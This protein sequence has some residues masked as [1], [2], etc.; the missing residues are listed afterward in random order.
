MLL[1]VLLVSLGSVNVCAGDDDDANEISDC[2]GLE[3]IDNDL[4][5]DYILVN[6]IDCSDHGNFDRIGNFSGTF[7]GDDYVI[8][9]ITIVNDG[10]DAYVGFFSQ[11]TAGATVQNVTFKDFTITN[12]GDSAYVG[13]L[14]GI[15]SDATVHHVRFI[16]LTLNLTD[17]AAEASYVGGAIGI[18][19]NM[20]ISEVAIMGDSVV[21]AD[22][23][24]GGLIGILDNDGGDGTDQLVDSFSTADVNA[25]DYVGG[26]VGNTSLVLDGDG[27]EISR[28]YVTG[29]VVG[30]GGNFVGA[31]VGTNVDFD[32]S[33]T[34]FRYNFATGTALD[35][36]YGSGADSTY[37]SDNYYTGSLCSA[38][39]TAGCI[40]D[41]DETTW[42]N[43]EST[44]PLNQWDFDDVWV[45]QANALPI[46]RFDPVIEED[47]AVDSLTNDSTPSYV[48][49]STGAGDITYGGDCSS[50]TDTAVAGENTIVFEELDDGTYDDCTITV[51]DS[52][53]IDSNVLAITAFS[54]DS[55]NPTMTLA[56]STV[57]ENDY[58]NSE[59][60][61]FTATFSEDV[62][63]FTSGDVTISN[64]TLSGFTT[65]TAN[66][67]YSFNVIPRTSGEVTVSIADGAAEDSAE[68]DTE[69]DFFSFGFSDPGGG[70]VAQLLKLRNSKQNGVEGGSA[71]AD[72][73]ASFKDIDGHF[74]EESVEKLYELGIVEGRG[75]GNFEPN[76]F[77]TRAEMVKMALLAFD[78]EIDAD[79]GVLE[80]F[81]DLLEG[82]WYMKYLS[83]AVKSEILKGYDGNILRPDGFVTRAEALKVLL[84]CAE[85]S[86][87]NPKSSSFTDVGEQ[88]WFKE[89]VD[90]AYL[91]GVIKGR[92]A[93]I[94]APNEFATRGE[95]A[96]MITRLFEWMEL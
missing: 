17:G 79:I 23:Y 42:Y 92:T 74:A 38:G 26:F 27:G 88:D 47:T 10:D 32:E 55:E 66:R 7:D 5:A 77:L 15:A 18:A 78:Y 29:D 96:V 68:N 87:R 73:G 84:L 48:F 70:N 31:F 21:N 94:F 43:S 13:A 14:A 62:T 30:T 64:G 54:I 63:G 24:V 61:A 75:D 85:A 1:L 51:A 44:A 56:S 39:L 71:S 6:D 82:A 67:V 86:I 58:T 45:K 4:S 25:D 93:T 76:A 22:V 11:L 53:D 46:L 59:T 8:T 52:N 19:L 37:A 81:V 2:D 95:A 40:R 9:G 35:G 41:V 65:V 28:N 12:D 91:L 83:M 33:S 90:T 89:F 72:G 16:D 3:A 60:V 49:T 80:N 50:E 57:E 20:D 34:R 36:F 69:A